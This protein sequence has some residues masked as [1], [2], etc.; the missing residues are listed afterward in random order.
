MGSA[1]D[2]GAVLVIYGSATGLNTGNVQLLTQDKAG[3][4]AETGDRFG[5][6]LISGDF[7]ADGRDDLAIGVPLE[8][9]NGQVDA[10]MA[11]VFYGGSSRLDEVGTQTYVDQT[12][13]AGDYFGAALASGDYDPNQRDDLAIGVPGEDITFNSGG[14]KSDTGKALVYLNNSNASPRTLT[15]SDFNFA[16]AVQDNA[17]F[18][19]TL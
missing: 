8:D 12:I 10:G 7:N 19:A 11:H 18:G 13:E 9:V 14:S 5:T 1:Q 16:G 2:A 6:S 15:L 3:N 17:Y 4:A